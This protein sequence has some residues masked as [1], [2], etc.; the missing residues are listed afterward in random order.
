MQ[1][2]L[3]DVDG[4]I[5]DPVKRE[6]TKPE[7]IT[8]LLALLQQG[9]PIAF[10]SGRGLIWMRSRVIKVL[11]K[12]LDD[13]PVLDRNALD[14]LYISGEFGGVSAVYQQGQRQ[15][16]V[17]KALM[18]PQGVRSMLEMKAQ[19]FIEYV[20][21]DIEKQTQFTV[22]ANFNKNTN[23]MDDHGDDIADDFRTVIQ[24]QPELEV[25]VDRIA[26]NVKNKQAN[27][28]Y[29]TDQFLQWLANKNF[30]PEKYI[31]FGDSPTDL[32]I[33]EQLQAKNLPFDFVYVGE[34]TDLAESNPQFSIH[35]TNAHCDV[36]TVEFLTKHYFPESAKR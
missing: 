22:E 9:S 13:H 3:F 5:T 4:V 23:L 2:Y 14:N 35:I 1:A 26:V 27:K 36:G 12:Y 8:Q 24:G 6:I 21:V 10:I 30:Q 15:E 32:E 17:N 11:E 31:V 18:I 33:G 19:S 34:K 28:R 20:F 29:A 25:Q 7:L 16:E